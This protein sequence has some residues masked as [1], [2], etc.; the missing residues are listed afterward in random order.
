MEKILTLFKR[1][2]N[3]AFIYLATLFLSLQYFSTIYVN[4]SFL[5]QTISSSVLSSLYVLG[6]LISIVVFVFFTPLLRK[7]GNTTLFT[8]LVIVE[9][10][11]ILGLA[12]FKTPPLILIA[13]VFQQ[14]CSPLIFFTLD[15]FLESTAHQ[16]EKTGG[17]R[18]LFLFASNIAL[19]LSP[20]II[21]ILVRGDNFSL[22]YIASS[23]FL[24]P[25]LLIARAVFVHFPDAPYLPFRIQQ[26]LLTF[27]KD[28]NIRGVFVAN[29]L[30]QLFYAAMVIY[31]PLY[32]RGLGLS[33]QEIGI[34]FSFMLLP[35]VL[36][37]LPLGYL[38]D[39]HLGEKELMVFGFVVLSSST[40]AIAF[41]TGSSIL[42][43][44][45]LLFITRT[46]ASFIE[47]AS[48][49]Y[50]FKHVKGKEASMISLFRMTV[51]L[52]FIVAPS[53]GAVALFI[54]NFNSVF[55]LFG[56]ILL[57]G[58]PFALSLKDT[59]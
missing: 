55:I 17:L 5:S 6:A 54:L 53:L 39:K 29:F 13:F 7:F 46:G 34:I 25:P 20:L 11:A 4:S 18:G 19:V 15:V 9:I 32:L 48:E 35:F 12:L 51:P 37:E 38:A 40:A 58:I 49:S 24:L 10:F 28:K 2:K 33:W 45:I 57:S 50:F 44:A 41:F 8:S 43:W 31:M 16:E 26:T 30:L 47:I 59:L 23:L 14:A 22:V 3:F 52:S 1:R 42:F 27:I 56:V 36:F 21:S